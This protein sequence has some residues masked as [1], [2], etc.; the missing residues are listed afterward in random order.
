MWY[1]WV[2]TT[3]WLVTV[4]GKRIGTARMPRTS[5]YARLC[6]QAYG[7]PL[8]DSSKEFFDELLLRRV[9]FTWWMNLCRSR[10]CN[11]KTIISILQEMK[12]GKTLMVVHHDLTLP[13]SILINSLLNMR[14]VAFG[15]VSEV[16]ILITSKPMEVNWLCQKWQQ[17]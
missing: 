16:Y 11:G 15:S 3:P 6:R 4:L 5:K 7:N 10:C 2:A 12:A 17:R 13:R 14:K 8:A 1:W 9:L